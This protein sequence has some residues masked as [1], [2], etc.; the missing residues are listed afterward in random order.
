MLQLSYLSLPVLAT[1]RIVHRD[2]K[3]HNILL[4]LDERSRILEVKLAD[5]GLAKQLDVRKGYATK[6]IGSRRWMA[7]EVQSGDMKYD[8]RCDIWS[9]GLTL[10]ECVTLELP[11]P[12]VT[13]L[14][15]KQIILSGTAPAF[16]IA[17]TQRRKPEYLPVLDII[18]RCLTRDA[19]ARPTAAQLLEKPLF[20]EL[21]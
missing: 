14:D 8:M 6:S 3:S 20:H 17:D 18:Q 15:T 4:N 7:P 1:H 16:D 10:V 19:V 5:F 13:A 9:F 11:F 12:G 21:T 2:I